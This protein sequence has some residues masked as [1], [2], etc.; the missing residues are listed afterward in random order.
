MHPNRA[1]S[2]LRT[3]RCAHPNWGQPQF[4]S[5]GKVLAHLLRNSR[6]FSR[7]DFWR[8]QGIK[9]VTKSGFQEPTPERRSVRRGKSLGDEESDDE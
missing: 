6:A 8:S 3:N 7:F 2:D 5:P 1:D 9:G 4:A